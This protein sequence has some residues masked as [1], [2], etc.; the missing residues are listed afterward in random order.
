M[1]KKRNSCHNLYIFYVFLALLWVL[2]VNLDGFLKFWSE[3]QKSKM[4]AFRTNDIIPRSYDIILRTARETV[5]S[6]LQVALS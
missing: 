2:W 3:I 4:V 5:L 1:K 6:T